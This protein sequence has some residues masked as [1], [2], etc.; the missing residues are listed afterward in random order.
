MQKISIETLVKKQ[1]KQK[2]N[3]EETDTEAWQKM[4][5]TSQKSIKKY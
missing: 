2:D 4:K 5:R 3:M 1:K